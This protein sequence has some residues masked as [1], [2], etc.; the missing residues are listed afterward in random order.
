MANASNRGS[1][2]GRDDFFDKG[3]KKESTE[4]F[5]GQNNID[6][7]KYRDDDINHEPTESVRHFNFEPNYIAGGD[8]KGKGG[9][10]LFDFK[11]SGPQWLPWSYNLFY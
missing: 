1:G 6:K 4:L 10:M 7:G 9:Q 5:P 11:P 8:E 3:G 2:N